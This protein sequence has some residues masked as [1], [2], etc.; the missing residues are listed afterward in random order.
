MHCNQLVPDFRLIHHSHEMRS[1]LSIPSTSPYKHVVRINSHFVCSWSHYYSSRLYHKCLWRRTPLSPKNSS[2]LTLPNRHCDPIRGCLNTLVPYRSIQSWY[3]LSLDVYHDLTNLN[4][5]IWEMES[6]V[7]FLFRY[8]SY[9]MSSRLLPSSLVVLL[10][11]NFHCW[12]TLL[13]HEGFLVDRS[14][15]LNVDHRWLW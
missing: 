2:C 11:L 7:Q 15:F 14:C 8:C 1:E 6:L 3:V 4:R 12:W 9:Q 13:F 10:D 5:A